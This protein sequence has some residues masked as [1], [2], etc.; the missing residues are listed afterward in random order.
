M[1][2]KNSEIAE[3]ITIENVDI[4][5]KSALPKASMYFDITLI[6]NMSKATTANTKALNFPKRYAELRKPLFL[7]FILE[8]IWG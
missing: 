2:V 1:L 7:K 6:M 5:E 8:E 4:I 3:T